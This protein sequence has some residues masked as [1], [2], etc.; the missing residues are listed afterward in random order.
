[1]DSEGFKVWLNDVLAEKSVRY[2]KDLASRAKRVEKTFQELDSNFSL[3]EE[4]KRD[5]GERL[6]GKLRLFG[7]ALEGTGINL[8]LN[9]NQMSPIAAAVKWY[10]KYLSELE[11]QNR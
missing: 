5:K 7:K 4:Y 2:R 9:T 11:G 10:F 3:D 6:N 1:M 8:P